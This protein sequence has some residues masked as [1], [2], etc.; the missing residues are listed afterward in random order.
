VHAVEVPEGEHD[1]TERRRDV[2]QVTNH[3]H[4]MRP[5]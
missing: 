2:R 1:A 5:V 3:P 4:S